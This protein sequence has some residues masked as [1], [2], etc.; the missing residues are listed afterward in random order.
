[1]PREASVKLTL[2][3][4][5]YVDETAKV[6]AETKAAEE[7]IKALGNEVDKAERDLKS[8][9]ITNAV[10]AKEVDG[11]GDKAKGT[12]V[13]LTVLDR[14]IAAARRSLA[15]MNLELIATGGS[16]S[17]LGGRVNKQRSLLSALEALRADLD[18]MEKSEVGPALERLV[19]DAE[20]AGKRAGSGFAR[21]LGS[22]LDLGGE[23]IKPIH[24]LIGG[25]V[26]LAVAAAPAI[27]AAISGAIVGA[28][29]V[30][31]I[32]GGVVAASKSPA[33]QSA[34]QQFGMDAKD[35]FSKM[36]EAFVD[37]VRASLAILDETIHNLD[38]KDTFAIAAPYVETLAHGLQLMA[39]NFMPGFRQALQAAG[40]YV[41]E[42]AH[43]LGIIGKALGNFIAN[44]TNSRG[45]L[46]GLKFFLGGIAATINFLGN[47]LRWLSDRF[48][49]F[50][51]GMIIVMR[52]AAKVADAMG[53]HGLAQSLRDSADEVD[54]FVFGQHD[55]YISNMKLGESFTA[56][57]AATEAYRKAIMDSEQ[58]VDDYI[59]KMLGVSDA[60]IAV[61]QGWDDLSEKLIRG[62]GNWDTTTQAGR[63]NIRMVNDQIRALEAQRQQAIA[64]SD[65]SVQAID[66]I[67]RKFNEQLTKLENIARGAGDSKAALDALEG[68]YHIQIVEDVIVRNQL[69][70]AAA[71]DKA[72]GFASGGETPASEV[73]KVG[74]HGTEYL[75]S[76]KQ[77][78]VATKQQMMAQAQT[79]SGAVSGASNVAVAVTVAPTGDKLMDVILQQLRFRVIGNGGLSAT[80]SGSRA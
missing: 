17:A 76:D 63:D 42:L 27:G 65:G 44:L 56:S 11:L 79:W 67:N 49:H 9:A 28:V 6:L 59:N 13:D 18:K 33:V 14:R 1:M 21:N 77:H 25:L 37:P 43:G 36:G 45:S 15:A 74:E 29:G 54:R 26:V 3:A 47:A 34:W 7:E 20:V 71:V 69:N 30:G 73:F 58:A 12:A 23:G 57:A 19:G 5:S 41:A 46:E 78:Y 64:T 4:T 22:G 75:F 8:F 24:A 50:N 55:L 40:P 39:E 51:Q 66:A 53:Q 72:M 16:D 52:G 10:A 31:G 62:K 2:Q 32:V 38:L 80:F 60:N 61:A 70:K 48:D 35:E 68:T